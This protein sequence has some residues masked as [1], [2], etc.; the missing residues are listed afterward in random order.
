MERTGR[1]LEQILARSI[2]FAAVWRRYAPY[3]AHSPLYLSHS[4]AYLAHSPPYPRLS[5]VYLS[6]SPLYLSHS[7]A[8]LAHSSPYLLHTARSGRFR[9]PGRPLQQPVRIEHLRGQLELPTATSDPWRRRIRQA[10]HL[11]EDDQKCLSMPACFRT[12]FAVCRDLTAVSEEEE[13]LELRRE[14]RA[15]S[16]GEEDS[17]PTVARELESDGLG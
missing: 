13:L 6:H 3:L 5:R 10:R 14:R 4:P 11:P 9:R 2:P 15:H 7:P 1:R 8:Y 16:G 17:F 12:P